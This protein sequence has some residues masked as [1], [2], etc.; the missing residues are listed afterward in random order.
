L[1]VLLFGTFR[2]K[3]TFD[4][5][6]REWHAFSLLK[7][8]DQAKDCGIEEF[9]ALEFGVAHGNGL[10]NIVSLAQ[11]VTRT[12]GVR[13]K[14]VGFDSGTGMPDPIDY[15]D[16][17]NMYHRGEFP[18]DYPRL[19]AALPTEAELVIGEVKDTLG[20]WL[21]ENEGKRPIGFVSV[22]LDYYSSTAEA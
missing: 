12:T 3:V 15:R 6:L 14:V 22:D 16:H 17:P 1:A 5:V 10:K 9:T 4:L 2:L 13:I 21:R 11:R 7:A 20:A 18:M 8:A 19:R